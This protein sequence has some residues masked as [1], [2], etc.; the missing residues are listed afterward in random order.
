VTGTPLA[1]AGRQ[2]NVAMRVGS[3]LFPA[4]G[5]DADALFRNAEAG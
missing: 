2:V 4:D 1:V 5:R 3:A